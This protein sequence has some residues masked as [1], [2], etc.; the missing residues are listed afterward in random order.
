MYTQFVMDY[1]DK[2][3]NDFFIVIY[4]WFDKSNYCYGIARFYTYFAYEIKFNL[5]ILF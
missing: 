2:H 4:W 3:Q 1:H 5:T